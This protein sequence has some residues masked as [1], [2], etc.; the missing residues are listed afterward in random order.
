MPVGSTVEVVRVAHGEPVPD[1]FR[2][3]PP[4]KTRT[5]HDRYGVAAVRKLGP[6]KPA[7]VIGE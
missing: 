5:H 7:S 2:A 1:G 3:N 4:P 6:R